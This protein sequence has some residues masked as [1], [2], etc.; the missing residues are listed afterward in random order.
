MRKKNHVYACTSGLKSLHRT[1]T[2]NFMGDKNRGHGGDPSTQSR[3][4]RCCVNTP[5]LFLKG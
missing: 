3:V 5:V 4:R 2:G 1:E